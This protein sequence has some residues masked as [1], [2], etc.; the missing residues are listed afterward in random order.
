VTKAF[1]AIIVGAGVIGTS[2]GYQLA[3]RGWRTLNID[4]LSASGQGSTSSSLAIIRTHYSS[5]EGCALAWVGYHYCA[6]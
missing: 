4:R 2:I 1:D 6:N 3:R 5:C